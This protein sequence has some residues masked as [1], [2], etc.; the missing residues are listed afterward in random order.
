M[1]RRA[2]AAGHRCRRAAAL[3]VLL[4]LGAYAIGSWTGGDAQQPAELP[5]SS[6]KPLQPRKG[7]TRAGAIY[8]KAVRP[9]CRSD[10]RRLRHRLPVDDTGTIVTNAH[11]VEHG[12]ARRPCASAPTAATSTGKVLGIDPSSDLAVVAHRAGQR[13]EGAKPLP[14]ADSRSVQVGDT[15]IAIGNPFGLDRTATEG[16]VSGLGRADPGAERFEIDDAIQTDAPINPGNSGGPLLDDSGRVIGINSQIETGGSSQGN[17]G[18]GFAVASNTVRQV[19]PKL[20]AGQSD[21]ARVARR[22]DHDAAVR[23][24]RAGRVGHRPAGPPSAPASQAG[25]HHQVDRRQAV[26]DFSNIAQAVNAKR[27][28]DTGQARDHP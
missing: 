7:Q 10:Q 18:I 3:V 27:P 23:P 4:V 13:A 20:E 26:N 11:V 12:Q 14:L 15:A 8:A 28:G 24:G 9:S 25:R 22:R 16:I 1:A 2:R 21:Q 19:V 6:G 5:A 17:V